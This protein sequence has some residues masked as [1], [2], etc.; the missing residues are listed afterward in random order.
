MNGPGVFLDSFDPS[1]FL[2]CFIF[3]PVHTHHLHGHTIHAN[4][5]T[6][7]ETVEERDNGVDFRLVF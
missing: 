4:M 6:G 7:E 2:R 1:L 5:Y 3:Y